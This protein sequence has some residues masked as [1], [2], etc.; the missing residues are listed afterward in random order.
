MSEPGEADQPTKKD[1]FLDKPQTREEAIW[2]QDQALSLLRDAYKNVPDVLRL[3]QWQGSAYTLPPSVSGNPLYQNIYG[4]RIVTPDTIEIS[5]GAVRNPSRR[6][7]SEPKDEGFRFQRP[8]PMYRGEKDVETEH[9]VLTFEG[10]LEVLPTRNNP[11]RAP[12]SVK[13]GQAIL[14]FARSFSGAK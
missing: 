9:V 13:G 12:G 3:L 8:A 5:F 2:T 10:K 1:R 14:R 4:S 6:V 11:L 7:E